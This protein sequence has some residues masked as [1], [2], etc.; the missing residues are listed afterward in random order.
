MGIPELFM[1]FS[2]M[3]LRI[4]WP[5]CIVGVGRLVVQT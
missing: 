4:L 5:A 2:V 1:L 3:G